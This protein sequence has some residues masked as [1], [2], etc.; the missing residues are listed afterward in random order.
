[1]WLQQGHKYMA[2]EVAPPEPEMRTIMLRVRML[3]SVR[4]KLE[5]L[6]NAQS[7]SMSNYL[8]VL[9][10]QQEEPGPQARPRSRK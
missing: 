6:A 2:K 8:E 4:K 10:Q 3:P 1:M 7:R 5:R 9:I